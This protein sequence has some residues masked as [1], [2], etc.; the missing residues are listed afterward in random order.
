MAVFPWQEEPRSSEPRTSRE[1]EEEA[2]RLGVSFPANVKTVR[3]K[4]AYLRQVTKP[5]EEDDE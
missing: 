3:Q 1:L 4:I 2:L 5:K